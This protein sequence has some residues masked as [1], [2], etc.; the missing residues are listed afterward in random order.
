MVEL[1][2]VFDDILPYRIWT[3][4]GFGD[5][6]RQLWKFRIGWNLERYIVKIIAGDIL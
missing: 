1:S 4:K 2:D 6:A 5:E 3:S